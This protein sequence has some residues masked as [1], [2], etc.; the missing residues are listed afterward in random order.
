MER[1]AEKEAKLRAMTPDERCEHDKR[2]QE[3]RE[4]NRAS[5][6]SWNAWVEENGIPYSEYRQF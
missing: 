6:E 2:R 5:I 1:L 3:W 4:E